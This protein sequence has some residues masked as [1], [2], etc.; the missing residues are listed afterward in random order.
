MASDELDLYSNHL[1]GGKS[2]FKDELNEISDKNYESLNS[3]DKKVLRL[4]KKRIIEQRN[5]IEK[6]KKEI[7]SLKK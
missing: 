4:Y 6:L 2:K 7:V 3:D 1:F 5:E